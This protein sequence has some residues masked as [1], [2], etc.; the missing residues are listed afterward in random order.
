MSFVR[1]HHVGMIAASLDQARHVYG[2]GFGMGVD[3]DSSSADAAIA[4]PF[5]SVKRLVLP[6]GETYL[7]VNQ[8]TDPSSPAGQFL[9]Q[10]GVGGMHY[11]SLASDRLAQDV[12]TLLHRGLKLLLPPDV[13]DWDGVSP[14][15]LDP[16]SAQGLLLQI[17]PNDPYYPHPAYRGLGVFTGLAHVGLAARDVEQTQRF[18]SD[19]F[20]LSLLPYRDRQEGE[21]RNPGAAIDPVTIRSFPIGGSVIE[22]SHPDDKVSGTARFVEWQ[23]TLGSAYH[24]IC[25]WAPDV[26]RSVDMGRAA[27][28][29]QIGSIPTKEESATAVA[30]FHPKSCLGTLMEI[31]NMPAPSQA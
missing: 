22:V 19:L 5:G 15:Y 17:A 20:G 1:V 31:W 28:L 24:H 25:P 8:P 16:E 13:K 2:D 10:R 30:W 9:A 3:E 14:V 26:H 7:E 18:W 27:G 6:I 12:E 4:T 11:V 23:A 21:E 29:Q